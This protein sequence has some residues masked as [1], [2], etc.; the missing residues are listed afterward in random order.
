MARGR[1]GTG[2]GSALSRATQRLTA[3]KARCSKD[4]F[5]AIRRLISAAS[6][7]RKKPRGGGRGARGPM[8]EAKRVAA[9]AKRRETMLARGWI[10]KGPRV[11]KG[12]TAR[13][14]EQ[15]AA[16]AAKRRDTLERKRIL[17]Y[18]ASLGLD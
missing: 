8:S 15:K 14:A 1:K 4:K 18:S 9:A 5:T 17:K 2:A 10:P 13:T 16:S 11:K 12:R 3:L 6:A 7:P